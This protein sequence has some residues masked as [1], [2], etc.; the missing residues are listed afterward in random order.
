MGVRGVGLTVT[1]QREKKMRS[2]GKFRFI[3][4]FP[5]AIAFVLLLNALVT[6]IASSMASDTSEISGHGTLTRVRSAPSVVEL[7]N[8]GD[9]A[10]NTFIRS[11]ARTGSDTL[12][13]IITGTSRSVDNRFIINTCIPELRHGAFRTI[14]SFDDVTVGD[15]RG[16][17]VL[18][19]IGHFQPRTVEIDGFP[20]AVD[21]EDGQIRILCGTGALRGISG[22]GIYNAT[23]IA[24]IPSTPPVSARDLRVYAISINFD[25]RPDAPDRSHDICKDLI[26]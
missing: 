18:E 7:S 6:P 16:G 17:A 8:C 9:A 21:T 5:A 15:R 12:S 13:G 25:D 22:T 11:G 19:F 23:N 26:P 1:L 20:V 2:S 10:G 3:H 14:V 4:C 24:S